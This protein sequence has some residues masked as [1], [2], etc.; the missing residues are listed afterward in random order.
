MP[1]YLFDL[2]ILALLAFFGWRGASRGFVLS[3]CGLAAVLTAFLGAQLVSNMFWQPVSHLIQPAIVRTILGTES[4]DHQAD[5][6]DNYSIDDLLTHVNEEGLFS[7][8]SS[9]LS[10]GVAQNAL[11]SEQL[12]PVNALANYLS[13]G[14]AKAVLFALAFLSILLIWFIA[15][16]A[17]NLAARLPI[18]ST[19]NWTG[20][21]LIGLAKAAVLIVVL[22]WLGQLAGWVPSAPDTPVLS[23]FTIHRLGRLLND[24]PM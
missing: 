6:R 24:F 13:K 2:L 8:F 16:R 7:G 9:F 1:T 11:Q 18:L 10:N 19:V 17:L 5:G 15:S 3:L 23:W 22:V 4:A 21:L 12:T 14:I 20:G